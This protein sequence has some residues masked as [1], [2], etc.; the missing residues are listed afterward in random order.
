MLTIEPALLVSRIMRKPYL[1]PSTTLSTSAVHS[2]RKS[3][4]EVS[5][6]ALV[7][8]DPAEL[9]SASTDVCLPVTASANAAQSL[10]EVT[11][12][13]WNSPLPP[14][15]STWRTVSA[16]RSGLRPVAMMWKPALTRRRA[17]A[18]P[19]PEVAPVTMAERV[20]R[21]SPIEKEAPSTTPVCPEPLGWLASHRS[22]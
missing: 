18:R 21:R 19:M 9:I 13:L 2:S 15:A 11:S 7:K 16:P 12:K 22:G 14:A 1:V 5:G 8:N 3:S 4:S 10:S 6:S 20:M 17:V